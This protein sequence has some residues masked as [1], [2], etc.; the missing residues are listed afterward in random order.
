MIAIVVAVVIFG[1]VM[2]FS[3]WLPALVNRPAWQ[4]LYVHLKNG[5]YANALFDRFMDAVRL[6]R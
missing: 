6:A 3:A 2:A 5:F 1:I 4:A